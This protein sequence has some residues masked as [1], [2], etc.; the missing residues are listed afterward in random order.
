[1]SSMISCLSRRR[2]SLLCLIV[3]FCMARTAHCHEIASHE[4]QTSAL[5]NRNLVVNDRSFVDP[6]QFA[7]L[8]ECQVLVSQPNPVAIVSPLRSSW[9]SLPR[10]RPGGTVRLHCVDLPAPRTKHVSHKSFTTSSRAMNRKP[11][12]M[13]LI[14]ATCVIKPF[15][16]PFP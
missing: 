15:P 10:P 2:S 14:T 5:R 4:S 3:L 16:L 6:A 8:V 11:Y 9:P 12:T 13:A 1:M 7:D